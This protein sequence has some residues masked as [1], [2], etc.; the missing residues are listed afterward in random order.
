MLPSKGASGGLLSV[1]DEDVIRKE[2]VF[3]SPRTVAILFRSV[4]DNFL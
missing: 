3:L 2:D 4:V 1:R